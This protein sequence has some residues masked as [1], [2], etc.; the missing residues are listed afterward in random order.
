MKTLTLTLAVLFGA[1]LGAVSYHLYTTQSLEARARSAAAAY[2]QARTDADQ[3]ALLAY[4][5]QVATVIEIA[6]ADRHDVVLPGD[7]T[8]E[9]VVD[10]IDVAPVTP[11]ASCTVTVSAGGEY[12]IDAVTE[13]GN[14][15]THG[16]P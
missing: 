13:A 9:Y 7:C 15:A 16:W 10:G 2:Q 5:R 11:L 8:R 1:A 14:A 4:L 12:R 6:R 3:R